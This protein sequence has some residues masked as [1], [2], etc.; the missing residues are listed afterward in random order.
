MTELSIAQLATMN[1]A[2]I[3]AL[4]VQHGYRPYRTQHGAQRV[5]S[6]PGTQKHDPWK[7]AANNRLFEI[8]QGEINA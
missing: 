2:Q 7:E 8:Q 3:A 6:R 1:E 5:G 4:A